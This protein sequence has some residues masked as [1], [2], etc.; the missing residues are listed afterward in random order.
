MAER[1][2]IASFDALSLHPAGVANNSMMHSIRQQRRFTAASIE[3]MVRY[4]G[5]QQLMHPYGKRK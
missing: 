5:V 4:D 1:K 3:T 2:N